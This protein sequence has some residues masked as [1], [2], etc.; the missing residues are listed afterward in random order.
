LTT[1]ISGLPAEKRPENVRKVVANMFTLLMFVRDDLKNQEIAGNIQAGKNVTVNSQFV[2]LGLFAKMISDASNATL[3]EMNSKVKKVTDLMNLTK[4]PM[5][6]NYSHTFDAE[7]KV[8][9]R[10]TMMY[11]TVA[12]AALFALIQYLND[13][14]NFDEEGGEE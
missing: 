9:V 5:A 13:T 1:I 14:L 10:Y 4:K 6:D 3:M 7:E 12:I 2:S 11:V 8:T